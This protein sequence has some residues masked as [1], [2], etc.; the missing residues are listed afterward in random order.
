MAH[1]P[2]IDFLHSLLISREKEWPDI[3]SAGIPPAVK[4]WAAKDMSLQEDLDTVWEDVFRSSPP[5][6]ELCGARSYVLTELGRIDEEGFTPLMSTAACIIRH[7][8]QDEEKQ[9]CCDML[10]VGMAVVRLLLAAGADP[11]TAY[12]GGKYGG[13]LHMAC[14][15]GH[16]ELV[17]LLLHYGANPCQEDTDFNWT[18]LHWA[19]QFNQLDCA[20]LLLAAG[21]DPNAPDLMGDTP[22]SHAIE[23]N[24]KEMETFLRAN[25]ASKLHYSVEEWKVYRSQH[26]DGLSST[27]NNSESAV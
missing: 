10:N 12:K 24:L 1:Q 22:L 15:G 26:P 6:C 2:T 8:A 16:K 14:S 25:G 17:G 11:N 3:R 21:A 5:L 7:F 27:C 20:R 23:L 9:P 4:N 19:T 13:P 18:P